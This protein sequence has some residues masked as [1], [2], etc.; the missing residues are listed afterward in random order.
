MIPIRERLHSLRIILSDGAMGTVL[1]QSRAGTPGDIVRLNLERPAL[2]EDIHRKYVS[3]GA[4]ILH[5][6]TF[7]CTS[8]ILGTR[9]KSPDESETIRR[10]VEIAGSAARGRCYVAGSIGPAGIAQPETVRLADAMNIQAEA[11]SCSGVDLV[12]IE[13]MTNLSEALLALKSIRDVDAALPVAVTF[14]FI[15]T[16]NGFES[17]GGEGLDRCVDDLL[18]AGADILGA[19]CVTIDDAVPIAERIRRITD[20]PLSIQPSA[21]LPIDKD[22]IPVYPDSLEY[23]TGKLSGLL[24]RGISIIGGCCGT[25]PEYIGSFK[26]FLDEHYSETI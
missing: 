23:M 14:A 26:R 25:T 12:S 24:A 20:A 21:G 7:P 13:T 6:N 11:F 3:A 17:L 9:D 22:G 19:N 16:K 18:G 10:A 8:S 2:I 5:T 4:E 15:A 1:I